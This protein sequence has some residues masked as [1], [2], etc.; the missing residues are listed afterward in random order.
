VPSVVGEPYDTARSTLTQAGFK[1]YRSPIDCGST[2]IYGDVAYQSPINVAPAG[3][4]ITLCV[5]NNQP[6]PLYVPP[7]PKPVV[8]KPKPGSSVPATTVPPPG[9]GRH[10]RPPGH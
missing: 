4:M 7:P 6:L 1:V 10:T 9:G 2:Q 3:S 5:S 8:K